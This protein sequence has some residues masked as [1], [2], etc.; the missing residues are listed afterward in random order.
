M[1]QQRARKP[2]RPA[3][4][5]KCFEGRRVLETRPDAPFPPD[6]MGCWPALSR[7]CG[8]CVGWRFR[9]PALQHGAQ[10]ERLD[11]VWW[12]CVLIWRGGAGLRLWLLGFASK[13]NA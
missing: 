8:R 11:V 10:C 9:R 12:D 5:G 3:L 4:L 1:R 7:L 6:V 2:F 13:L